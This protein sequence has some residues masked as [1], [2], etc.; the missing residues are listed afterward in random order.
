LRIICFLLVLSISPTL[1]LAQPATTKVAIIID[2]IGYHK[3]DPD[4][5]RLPYPLTL[6]VMPFTPNGDAM[7]QLAKQHQK[8][9]M[10]HMP[11]EAV[12]LNHLLGKGALRQHMSKTEVQQKL[13]AALQDVPGIKGVNNHMGSLYTTLSPQ[14][15]WVMEV[16]A[17]QGLYFIDSKTSGRSVVG[18]SAQK[19]N[20]R[21]RSRDVFLDNDKSYAALDKQFQQLISVAHRHGSA[22]AIGHPYPETYRYLKKNLPR[23]AAAGIELVPAS[24]LLDMPEALNRQVQP[25]ADPVELP[26]PPIDKTAGSS[27]QTPPEPP[28]EQIAAQSAH[29]ASNAMTSG[30]GDP[31][32]ALTVAT[33]AEPAQQSSTETQAVPSASSEL[34]VWR[35][36]LQAEPAWFKLPDHPAAAPLNNDSPLSL[37]HWYSLPTKATDKRMAKPCCWSAGD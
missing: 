5:I 4:L 2:D 37:T 12:A 26:V 28:I 8:E 15:D 16:V 27:T 34:P 24:H 22:I 20:I 6:A 23:L 9:L 30:A 7:L 31:P 29:A 21:H 32:V 19:F 33:A 3:T 35:F 11:M 13:R 17:T 14:M 1:S 18:Q 10:L 36:P 25:Q